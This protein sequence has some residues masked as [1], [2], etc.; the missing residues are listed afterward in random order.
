[1]DCISRRTVEQVTGISGSAQPDGQLMSILIFSNIG[2]GKLDFTELKLL[3]TLSLFHLHAVPWMSRLSGP[4]RFGTQVQ[5][6]PLGF[7]EWKMLES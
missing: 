5:L 1:M 2:N 3:E 4:V 7:P 6:W